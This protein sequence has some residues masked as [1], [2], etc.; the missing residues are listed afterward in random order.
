MGLVVHQRPLRQ[1]VRRLVVLAV[2]PL[3]LTRAGFF[4]SLRRASSGTRGVRV[5][6]ASV[7]PDLV[8]RKD[9]GWAL[10]GRLGDSIGY[11]PVLPGVHRVT[12]RYIE[13]RRSSCMRLSLREGSRF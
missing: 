9:W 6:T 11:Y 4:V 2:A 8:A 10:V 13:R 7:F 12:G 5:L 1:S 3:V